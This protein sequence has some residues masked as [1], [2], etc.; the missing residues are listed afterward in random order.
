MV[1]ALRARGLPVAYLPFPG[2][3]HGFRQAEHIARALD[4]ELSFYS[5]IC[6]FPLGG[7][8]EPLPIENR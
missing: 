5:R 8:V 2:E 6:D 7:D 4:A 1:A 3:Q